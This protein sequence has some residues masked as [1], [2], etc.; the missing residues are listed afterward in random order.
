[1]RVSYNPTGGIRNACLGLAVL[2][3]VATASAMVILLII[4]LPDDDDKKHASD[5]NRYKHAAI[6]TDSETCSNIGRYAGQVLC[7]IQGG[8]VGIGGGGG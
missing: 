7:T 2:I 8:G 4:Y 3:M 1:M 6:A 5:E